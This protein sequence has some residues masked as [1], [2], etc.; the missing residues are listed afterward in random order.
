MESDTSID[1]KPTGRLRGPLRKKDSNLWE[2]ERNDHYVEPEWCSLRLFE[3]EKFEGN[4]TDPSCGFGNIVKSARASGHEAFGYDLVR[5]ADEDI[6]AGLSD[7][8]DPLWE[9]PHPVHNIVSNPPF[10]L[11]DSRDG[12][13]GY[14]ELAVRRVERKAALLLPAN[15]VQGD[16]RSRWM[17]T[18][19][20]RK[21]LFIAPRPSMPPGHVIKAGVRPGNGTTDYAFFLFLKGYDGR[22]EVGWLRKNP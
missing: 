13:P 16:K 2:R 18:M 10:G 21:V 7:F 20:L 19:P 3:Q 22:P 4:I 14:V 8:M 17:E 11:C 12:K 9:S 6:C 5:R 1:E 15:W